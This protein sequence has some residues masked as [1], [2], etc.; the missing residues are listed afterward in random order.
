MFVVENYANTHVLKQRL[1][2]H[3]N[4]GKV[5][6]C[7][8]TSL[9]L[10]AGR[11]EFEDGLIGV[12]LEVRVGHHSDC[13]KPFLEPKCDGKSPWRQCTPWRLLIARQS[14]PSPEICRISRQRKTKFLSWVCMQKSNLDTVWC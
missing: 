11:M 10:V 7:F 3:R 1:H 12:Q 6:K 14:T 2:L 8:T 5:L 9:G 13:I 4:S